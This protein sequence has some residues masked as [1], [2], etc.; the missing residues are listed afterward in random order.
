MMNGTCR[1]TIPY[2]R[3]LPG[4]IILIHHWRAIY[5]PPVSPW[6]GIITIYYRCF[7]FVW[8]CSLASW[9]MYLY[10]V[11]NYSKTA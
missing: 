9:Y 7:D 8:V 11:Y 2:T 3:Y 5:G 6:H 10:K 1:R 4:D